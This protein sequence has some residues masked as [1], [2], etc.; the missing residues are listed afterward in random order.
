M[1]I[2]NEGA[3]LTRTFQTG[4]PAG[5]YCNVISGDYSNGSCSGTVVAVDGSGNATLTVSRLLCRSTAR[6]R[7]D[8]DDA[9]THSDS[10]AN[11]D[12]P[13]TPG[14]NASMTFNEVAD[15]N[16]GQN[17]FVVGN[18]SALGNWSTTAG[19]ALQWISGS[20]TR[21]NWHATK[22]STAGQRE[23]PVQ[24]HQEERQRQRG[25]GKRRRPRAQHRGSRCFTDRERHLEVRPTVA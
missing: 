2:N 10:C 24:V 11:S 22:R 18:V 19:V 5:N 3:A 21:G 25:V 7:Q 12:S 4:L 13:Q 20:G 9:D 14:G 16:Y 6:R 1:V 17:I 15:T 8:G 23:H